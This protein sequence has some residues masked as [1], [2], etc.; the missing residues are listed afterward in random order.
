[1]ISGHGDVTEDEF[2]AHY[3]SRLESAI[4][5]NSKFIVGDF[6]G[7]DVMSVKFLL[8][9]GVDSTNITIYHMSKKPRKYFDEIIKTN[10]NINL[11]GGFKSDEERDGQMTND[12]EEDILWIRKD[13]NM[14]G[15]DSTYI[16]GTERNY[17]RRIN[18][19][20]S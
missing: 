4:K 6:R 12:S 10:K 11:Q 1:M 14:P 16:S 2:N 9:N 15:Y 19:H 5:M 3:K 20:K 13:I 7:C 17:L 8:A 18:A